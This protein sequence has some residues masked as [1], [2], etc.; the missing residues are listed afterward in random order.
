MN[1]ICI[2]VGASSALKEGNFLSM[3]GVREHYKSIQKTDHFCNA[4]KV[5]DQAGHC[6]PYN[7]LLN[8][9]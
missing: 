2:D 3:M 4:M 5:P 1:D 6:T 9:A 8:S 7:L